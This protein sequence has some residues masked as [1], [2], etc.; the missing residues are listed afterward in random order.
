M[1]SP[2]SISL[3]PWRWTFNGDFNFIQ[4]SNINVSACLRY[5]VQ[6][7]CIWQ[8]LRRQRCGQ[9]HVALAT[10]VSMTT[11]ADSLY[12]CQYFL[13]V[14]FTLCESLSNVAPMLTKLWTLC[15]DLLNSP[16]ILVKAGHE[17]IAEALFMEYVMLML[18]TY[19][20]DVLVTWSLCYYLT[21]L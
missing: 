17:S 21:H 3:W 1:K 19:T 11:T 16:R 10:I 8:V 20:P 5:L 13:F 6:H 12:L 18:R 9:C 14:V 7:V 4:Y 2:T 15:K